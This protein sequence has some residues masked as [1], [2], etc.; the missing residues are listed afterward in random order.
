MN[1]VL[2]LITCPDKVGLVALISRI[3]ANHEL[4]IIAMREFVDT[5]TAT[6]FTRIEC[7]GFLNN[8]KA[9]FNELTEHLPEG[10]AITINPKKEKKL[11]IMVTRE[12]HCLGDTLVRHFFNTK[13]CFITR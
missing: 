6:F 2:I 1:K 13:S 5:A 3:V 10:A 8:D 9:I 12:Y 11:A 4:N 7:Q